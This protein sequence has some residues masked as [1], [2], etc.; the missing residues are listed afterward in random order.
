MY[1]NGSAW[2]GP[3]AEVYPSGYKTET[4]NAPRYLT[5]R[6]DIW[7]NADKIIVRVQ[8]P[9]VESDGVEV[10]VEDET[11]TVLGR[12]AQFE[13]GELKPFHMESRL[14][15]FRRTFKLGDEI[16]VDSIEAS[17]RGGL[18]TLTLPVSQR[19]KPRKILINNS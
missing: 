14:G 6:A 19:V 5:P 16:D 7:K 11:L 18:L 1:P 3:V 15:D 10:D 9:G 13:P 2:C 4:R 8:M 12:V 17:M